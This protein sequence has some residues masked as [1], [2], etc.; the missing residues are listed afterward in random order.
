MKKIYSILLVAVAVLTGCNKWI[1]E[2]PIAKVATLD[3]V[4]TT[5]GL[6]DTGFT[7]TISG[8]DGV[9]YYA[10][11]VLEGP[12]GTVNA[13][14]L[15]QKGLGSPYAEG[16]VKYETTPSTTIKVTDLEANTQYTVYAIA[17]NSQSFTGNVVT[18]T[19]LTTDSNVPGFASARAVDGTIT[20]TYDEPVVRSEGEIRAYEFAKNISWL[21]PVDSYAVEESNISVNGS[22]MTVKVDAPAG[23]YV[24]LQF[25]DDVVRNLVGTPSEAYAPYEDG[26]Y[27]DWDD[28]DFDEAGYRYDVYTHIS[29]DTWEFEWSSDE[30]T[31]YIS[32]DEWSETAVL[33]ESERMMFNYGDTYYDSDYPVRVI[34]HEGGKYSSIPVKWDLYSAEGLYFYLPEPL[35]VLGTVDLSIEAGLFEDAY[36][37]PNAAFEYEEA[38]SCLLISTGIEGVYKATYQ[39]AWGDVWTSEIIFEDNEDGTYSVY[40]LSEYL[41]EYGF[42]GGIIATEEEDGLHIATGQSYLGSY[43]FIA[44]DP[45]LDE[46]CDYAKLSVLENGWLHMDNG[47][48]IYDEN[49]GYADAV[50]GDYD[51]IKISN[52]VPASATQTA[53]GVTVPARELKRK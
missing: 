34:Y 51:L 27:D 30:E 12:A 10:Y 9:T 42:F 21:D 39:D 17:G 14:R 28:D 19:V 43:L 49:N 6:Y 36:G 29:N 41:A 1:E 32:P 50:F 22:T 47:W 16:V 18:A 26:A 23:A 15:F 4:V 45:D 48:V 7:A 52:E 13:T 33:F 11:A 25:S 24:V 40:G 37:N 5:S 46:D 44:F 3:P 8:V 53:S 31:V 20:I 38:Y 35:D 2:E